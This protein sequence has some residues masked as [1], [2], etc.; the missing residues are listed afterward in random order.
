MCVVVKTII[1]EIEIIKLLVITVMI[2]TV[3]MII[4]VIYKIWKWCEVG[5]REMQHDMCKKN[6]KEKKKIKQTNK[7]K[8]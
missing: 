7:K 3:I 1:I 6:L 8:N 4:I 2:V 5:N